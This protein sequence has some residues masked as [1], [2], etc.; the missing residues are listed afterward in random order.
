[1]LKHLIDFVRLTIR[2][3]VKPVLETHSMGT[4]EDFSANKKNAK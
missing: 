3:Y 2:V 1:M 4:A